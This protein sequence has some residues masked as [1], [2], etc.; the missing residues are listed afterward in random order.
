MIVTVIVYS[1][2]RKEF[3]LD[4]VNS[5]IRQSYP[6]D[7]MQVIVVKGFQDSRIDEDLN[8]VADLVMVVDDP[9]HGAKLAPAIERAKGDLIFLLDDDD[10][11]TQDKI[12]R[13]T[14]LF[15]ADPNLLFVHNAETR[16]GSTGELL[17]GKDTLVP[18]APLFLETNQFGRK[19]ISL[20]LLYRANWFSSCM[21]F[22]KVVLSSLSSQIRKI[23]Q[24]I[25]P[26]LFMILFNFNGRIM[27]I[28]DRLTLYRVHQSTTNYA[29]DFE[30]FTR[31]RVN[32]YRRTVATYES[33]LLLLAFQR[34]KLLAEALLNHNYLLAVLVDPT[35]GRRDIFMASTLI[36]KILQ[37]Y[38]TRY[39]LSWSAFSLLRLIFPK[40][41][42]KIYYKISMKKIAGFN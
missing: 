16:I 29:A 21:A 22:R 42:L 3:I 2:K 7:Q 5:V 8:R 1:Y 13:I 27:L 11:F 35:S 31:R 26:F 39:L 14:Q 23:N 20:F 10:L 33:A 40:G 28:P 30:E 32:F 6:R 41:A 25:D 15:E 37:A 24:S 19:E 34:A 18:K 4:A 36:P 9:A 17:E 38:I 12:S